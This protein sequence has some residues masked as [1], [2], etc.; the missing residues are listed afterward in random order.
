MKFFN[1]DLHISVIAD[2]K[3][4]F[5]DLGHEVDDWSLS[6]HAWAFGS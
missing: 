6:G 1:I 5:T 3:K 2:I 4:I